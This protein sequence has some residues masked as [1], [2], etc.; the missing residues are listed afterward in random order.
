MA[1]ST[2]STEMVL[3]G[4]SPHMGPVGLERK[5]DLEIAQKSMAFTGVE[6]LS[7]RKLEQLNG[8]EQ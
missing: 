3:M 8:G 7:H 6:L 4:R 5:K 1:S 2:A